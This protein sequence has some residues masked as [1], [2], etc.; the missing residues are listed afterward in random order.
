MRSTFLV[1]IFQTLS[2]AE[3]SATRKFLQSPFFNQRSN[4]L[5]LFDLLVLQRSALETLHKKQIFAAL[6]PAQPYHN[7]TLN[8]LFAYL[9]E[10]LEQYLALV[11]MQRDGLTEQL[12]R[13]RAF[14]RRGLVQLFERD[15]Q[16]LEQAHLASPHRHAGWHLFH[17]Q[18]QY[19]LFSQRA[20]QRRIGE[21]NLQATVDALGQFFLL[22]N[23]RWACTAH[24]L[25]SV[26]GPTDYQLPLAGAVR[27]AAALATADQPALALL[28]HSL[29]ALQDPEDEAAFRQATALL[30]QCPQIF[31]LPRAA[32]CTWPPLISVSAARTA[33]RGT[34]RGKPWGFIAER[35]TAV[36]YS[37]TACC[38]NTPTTTSTCWRR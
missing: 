36:F 9:T 23:L 38:P 17:Y 30:T 20:V 24:S 27:D 28:A 25:R 33:V 14:R 1:Q 32:I 5:A 18:L 19:E 34:T 15:A 11:E 7:L 21:T 37:K 16:G 31:H 8:H 12:Y 29:R 22:E 35:W 3:L 13:V 2:P 6:F 10:R 26:G 4:V